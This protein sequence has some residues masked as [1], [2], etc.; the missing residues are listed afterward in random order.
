MNERGETP[1]YEEWERFQRHEDMEAARKDQA[2]V[3]G[4][5]TWPRHK[6]VGEHYD[7]EIL[8]HDQYTVLFPVCDAALQWFYRYLP[9]DTPRWGVNEYAMNG[10]KVESE[11]V[12]EILRGLYRD[13]LYSDRDRA[14]EENDRSRQHG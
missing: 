10:F 4:P 5:S 1:I 8:E 3:A 6:G 7:Y 2:I 13:H 12:D 14:D 11:R 9:E